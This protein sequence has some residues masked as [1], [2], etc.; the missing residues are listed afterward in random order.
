[1]SGN[2]IRA[3]FLCFMES[4][5][6][7][8]IPSAS[9]VPQN[10]PSVL[11]NTAGMQPL[12]PY[13]MGQPHASGRK[14]I[15]DSQKC[16]RTNDIDEVGDNTH[17]TF[18]EMLGNWSLGDYFKQEALTWSFEL[19]TS[20]T[21]GFGLD[22]KRLYV[23]VF[24]GDEN[25][26]RDEEAYVIWKEIFEKAG[27]DPEKRIFFM[28]A[29]SNWWSPGDNGPCGPDSE[30]FYDVSGTLTEGLTR[31]EFIAA[32]DRQDIVEIWNDVFM[33]YE[34]KDGKVVGKLA[35]QN[36]DTGSGLER[37][38]AVVQ[39]K[40]DVFATDLFVPI[41]DKIAEHSSKADP[42]AARVIAD[43]IRASTFLIA[44][45]VAPGNTDQGYIL[46]RLMRRAI[47]YADTLG[48]PA[49]SLVTLVPV[50]VN[51][52]GEA[53]PEVAVNEQNIARVISTEEEQFRK[54]LENGLKQFNKITLQI[55]MVS[56]IVD[57]KKVIDTSVAPTTK[58]AISGQNAFDL[59]TTYG[60]PIELT[61][62]IAAEKGL[63]VERKGF[64]KLMIEH[65]DLSRAGAEQKFKGGLADHSDQVVQYHTT[66][67]LLLKALQMV[68]GDQVKQRGSNITSERLR[69]DFSNDTKMTDEQKTEV[70]K[71]VNE[72]I[73]AGLPV[74]LN[75]LPKA[76]AELLG[77]EHEFGAKYPDTVTVY[78]IGPM[79]A[80]LEN[81]DFA[82]AFSLEFCGG[83]HVT[84][85][86]DIKGIFK[87]QKEESSSAGI[88]RIKG[89]LS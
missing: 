21:E 60:F 22:P 36:V 38:T 67:H 84:N 29:D 73:A 3:K 32:D 69:L 39:G 59:Y 63:V 79:G 78:S 80:T 61:E 75:T 48:M 15:A 52:Y 6:H 66:H 47:R 9:L 40:S 19:L 45:G 18:F 55:H 50:I 83:P 8:I 65:R 17:L 57:G 88:R 23:T 35:K 71:I 82:N 54:T 53:Y 5:G 44:D 58:Q 34:K 46:R 30:I 14:R 12:V 13:L 4:R 31:E 41:L 74:I 76:K 26:P 49:G 37:V 33:E 72:K 10:D 64:D 24:Q 51:L 16:V 1:M 77:A 43:H 7:A 85:T 25:A 27:L 68:L 2:E 87:I 70:E 11:F 56:K 86:S 42:R 62:E 20:K 28:D 81:P 89:V